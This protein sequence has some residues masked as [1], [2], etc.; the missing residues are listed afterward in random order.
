MYRLRMIIL[1]N[2]LLSYLSTHSYKVYLWRVLNA[3]TLQQ[4]FAINGQL[5]KMQIL[6]L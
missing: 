4:V 1:I 5:N 2:Y 3:S 6:S